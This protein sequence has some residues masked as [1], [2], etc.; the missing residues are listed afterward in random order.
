MFAQ[1]IASLKEA[2][3]PKY[4]VGCRRIGSLMCTDC[5][6]KVQFSY[7]PICPVCSEH[8]IGGQTHAGCRSAWGLD[9]L[10]SLT[11]YRGP[12]K[13]LVRQLKYQGATVHRE[14]ITAILYR[15]LEHESLMVPPAIIV[16]I[17]LN[18]KT[19]GKRGF[20]QSAIIADVL[21]DQMGLPSLS[22][23]L[24]RTR[25]TP[26]QTAL[27][28]DERRSNVAG[29]FALGEGQA[30]RGASFIVVDDVFTT[31]ATMHEATKVLKRHGAKTVWGFVLAQD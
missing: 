2:L 22:D 27:S 7:A 19:L 3:F 10:Q 13:R 29:A 17:P 28:R 11:Y 31:G 4:C 15:Y 18:A 23:V 5:W 25:L 20:N 24:T 21:A 8:S 9:G 30:V 12:I 1:A 26:S 14:L 16:P 6:A